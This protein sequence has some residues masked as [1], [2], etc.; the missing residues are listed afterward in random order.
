[1]A[2][3][4]EPN[5]ISEKRGRKKYVFIGLGMLV[6]LLI[7]FSSVLE[8]WFREFKRRQT[9]SG[10]EGGDL[11]FITLE[12]RRVSM[13]LARIPP[14]NLLTVFLRPARNYPDWNPADYRISFRA[15][16]MQDP[17][18]LDWHE[19]E[20]ILIPPQAWPDYDPLDLTGPEYP[21][22]ED[23][24][25]PSSLTFPPSMD[26]LVDLRIYRGDE[27]VWEGQRWSYGRAGHRH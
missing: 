17:A 8:P 3:V 9:P 14:T 4:D 20:R 16:D 24:Y 23:F 11:Y 2:Y 21:R 26:F 27:V 7:I 15:G 19:R 6:F 22:V 18:M 13:E 25:G 1:M 10:P 12:D 5:V